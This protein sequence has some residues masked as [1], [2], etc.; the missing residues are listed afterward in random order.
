MDDGAGSGKRAPDDGLSEGAG[1]K[2]RMALSIAPIEVPEE[3]E[4]SEQEDPALIE[5]PST[6]KVDS[7]FATLLSA[8]R[9]GPVRVCAVSAVCVAYVWYK[10]STESFYK[11][12]N[13][14]MK[15]R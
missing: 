2:R 10:R 1:K 3:E 4:Q 5:T 6:S 14:N 15:F 9:L 8:C 7:I 11:R 13:I 12:L